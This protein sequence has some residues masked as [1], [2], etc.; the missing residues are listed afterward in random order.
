MY[1]DSNTKKS[2]GGPFRKSC[3]ALLLPALALLPAPAPAAIT[4]TVNYQGFLMSKVSNQPLEV[5]QDIKFVIYDAASGG[6]ALFTESLC[7]VSLVKGRYDVE[8]G[9]ASGGIPVSHFIDNQALWLEIQVDADG[10]CTGAYEAMSPRVRLQASPYAFNSLYASTAAAAAVVFPAD[11]IAAHAQTANGGITI[12]TNLYVQGGISV[13]SISP[14]QKLSVAGVVE[15][16]GEGNGFMFPDG[17]LQTRAAGTTM[18]D[19]AGADLYSVN[20]GN[21]GLSTG[22]PQARFQIYSPAGTAGNILL[23]TTGTADVFRVTGAGSVYAS[24]YYG[25]GSTLSGLLRKAGDSMTGQLTL[26]GS[27]L[28]V[29][30]ALGISTPKMK[31]SANVEIS[32]APQAYYGGVYVS[33]HI[34]LAAGASYY[35]SGAGLT[36]LP[37]VLKT[38]DVMSGP[39]NITGS[40]LAVVNTNASDAFSFAVTSDPSLAVYHLYVATQGNVGIGTASPSSTLSVQGTVGAVSG[41]FSQTVTASS[42]VFTNVGGYSLETSSGINVAAGVVSAPYFSGN[43]SLLSGVQGTDS[44]RVMKA[45]DFMTGNLTVL[46]SSLSVISGDAQTYAFTVSSAAAMSAYSLA[47][48]TGGNVG[49]QVA[50]PSA[51]LEVYRQIKVSDPLGPASLSFNPYNSPGYMHWADSS[52]SGASQGALGFKAG[53]RDLIYRAGGSDP[54]SSGGGLEVFRVKADSTG[55]WLFGIGAAAPAESLHINANTLFGA[56][57][58]APVMYVS[59]SSSG[60]GISTTSITNKLTVAGGIMATSSITARG[61][62]YGDQNSLLTLNGGTVTVNGMF[63]VGTQTPGARFGVSESGSENYTMV[64]GTNPNE[65]VSYDLVVTTVGRVGIGAKFPAA[66]LHVVGGIQVGSDGINLSGPASIRLRHMDGD[67]SMIIFE[68]TSTQKKAVMGTPAGLDYFVFRSGSDALMSGLGSEEAYRIMRNGY[69]GIGSAAP[70]RKLDVTG[71]VVVRSSFVVTGQNLAASDYL[72]SLAGSTFNVKMDGKVGI[73]TDSPSLTLDV[74][75]AAV[76]GGG[77]SR[78]TFTA[79]GYW[80]PRRFTTAQVQALAPGAAG[81]VVGN[82]TISELCVSTGTAAGSWVV[83][84]SRGAD[85]CW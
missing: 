69:I 47:V 65:T 60:V 15:S 30:S 23:I 49:I 2:R 35:G 13:G 57:A 21:V 80:Q 7:D 72:F 29:T 9:S 85:P 70:D 10:S 3:F 56:S 37:T 53:E 18:W 44:A 20:A 46:S 52:L 43:G 32:S 5:P 33:S 58:A 4:Q 82:S 71:G 17:S 73:G 45:G 16:K 83:T 24:A 8:I 54:T 66:S 79:E 84:G 76:F 64:V 61:G 77:V 78:S 74:R 38:G 12:S 28:T 19:V 14:G 59:T 31:L 26:S 39:L 25:D 41:V 68:E 81:Q 1:H 75:G 27:S 67:G 11:T 36:N 50:A 62:Y 6:L 22:V 55:K 63:G 42:G 51:P 40:S 34:Y 48:T